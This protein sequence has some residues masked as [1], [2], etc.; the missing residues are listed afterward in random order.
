MSILSK[1][2]R[3]VA[4]VAALGV[5]A[6]LTGATATWGYW[7]TQGT[8]TVTTGSANLTVTTANFSTLGKTFANHS[9]VGTGS[10]TVTNSTTSTSSQLGAVTLV[11]SATGAA[12]YGSNFAFVVWLSTGANPCTDAATPGTTLASGTWNNTATY[13]T[14]GASGFAVGESRT[15]CV[16][17]TVNPAATWPASGAVTI[18]P[19]VDASIAVGNYS[20]TASATATQQTQ[21]L[22]PV[23][24]PTTTTG[25]YFYMHRVFTGTTTGNYCADLEGGGGPN[26]IGWPCKSGGTTN[27]SYRFDAVSGKPGYYTIKSNITAGPVLQQNTSGTPVTAVAAVVGQVNQQWTIQQTGTSYAGTSTRYFYQVINASTGQCLTYAT[28][29]GTSAALNQLQMAN[30][31]GTASQQFL[32][33][34]T[35]FSG[36]NGATDTVT[37]SYTNPNFRVG[38]TAGTPN[39]RYE[40]RIGGTAYTNVTLGATGTGTLSLPRTSLSG[41]GTF[42]YE[43]YEDTGATGD[44]GTLVA[45]GSITRANT[46]NSGSNVCSITG[47]GT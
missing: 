29:D 43:I 3:R 46:A 47:L 36:V 34:R 28:V 44:S 30:C 5:F 16:R 38:F 2:R 8:A 22:F 13:T 12:T 1:A 40:I 15:Y 11:F 10:V 25:A 35:M 21:Y 41:N 39:M 24:S 6:V 23:Y 17:T 9:L 7:T 32:L 4:A 18:T 27:Q 45:S 20:G 26:G 14:P 42:D 37:C 31:D 33:V 19:R